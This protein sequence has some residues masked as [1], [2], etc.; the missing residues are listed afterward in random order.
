M[1]QRE[2]TPT[3]RTDGREMLQPGVSC[4]YLTRNPHEQKTEQKNKPN[5]EEKTIQNNTGE[6]GIF[7]SDKSQ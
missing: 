2:G 7:F 1:L 3:E 6:I 5:F 4:G